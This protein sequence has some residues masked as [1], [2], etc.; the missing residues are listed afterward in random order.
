MGGLASGMMALRLFD[1]LGRMKDEFKNN[2][3]INPKIVED[4][5]I[6]TDKLPCCIYI[7][8]TIYSIVVN[9]FVVY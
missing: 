4:I 2:T 7:H 5:I 6:I 3:K 9:E 8:E 1:D